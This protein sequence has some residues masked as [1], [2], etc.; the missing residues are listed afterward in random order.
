[1]HLHRARAA[2]IH[3]IA[4]ALIPLSLAA[5]ARPAAADAPASIAVSSPATPISPA[6][7]VVGVAVSL[8]RADATPLAGFSIWVHLSAELTLAGGVAGVHEGPFL[9]ASGASTTLLAFDRGA[10]VWEVDGT[11]LGAPC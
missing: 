9:A 11:T 8:A 1:M 10:G 3:G 7:P 6:H 5:V 4:A 2:A